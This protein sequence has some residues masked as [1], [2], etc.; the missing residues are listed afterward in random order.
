MPEAENHPWWDDVAH[1]REAIERRR[2]D[3]ARRSRRAAARD[4]S[5]SAVEQLAPVASTSPRPRGA[6]EDRVASLTLGGDP[7]GS[8]TPADDAVARTTSMGDAGGSVATAFPPPATDGGPDSRRSMAR[9]A[10]MATDR[11]ELHGST[12]L[13]AERFEWEAVERRRRAE[14]ALAPAAV[15][16]LSPPPPRRRTVE[17]TGRTVGAPS[18]PR[19]IEIDRRR[20]PR[21]S[22]ERIGPR[23]DRLALWAVLLAFFLI[24]VAATSASHAA[25]Y[26]QGHGP[27]QPAI[28]R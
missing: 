9:P 13:V 6:S 11:A 15:Q 4:V 21:R 26:A 18:L 24:L 3:E 28:T 27:A 25:A 10:P 23:P 17:I 5:T 22:V 19:L 20:P 8:V 2:E 16:P 1:L 12:A 14:A 7:I